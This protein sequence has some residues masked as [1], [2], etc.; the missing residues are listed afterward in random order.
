M[1]PREQACR[2][3]GFVS[4]TPVGVVSFSKETRNIGIC[5]VRATA[6][7]PDGSTTVKLVHETEKAKPDWAGDTPLS[8]VVNALIRAPVLSTVLKMGARR[9]IIKTAE[10]KGI[11]WRQRCSELGRL[12]P[13]SQRAEILASIK[14]PDLQY[15]SYYLNSFHA[16]EAGNLGWLQ[17]FEVG[18]ATKS[19]CVRTFRSEAVLPDHVTAFDRMHESVF[20]AIAANAPVGWA[21]RESFTALDVGCGV[22][23]STRDLARRLL[24]HGVNVARVEG[25]D[26]S[27]YFLAVASVDSEPVGTDSTDV[28]HL[29]S[30]R[31]ALGERTHVEDD[32]LDLFTIQLTTHELPTYATRAIVQEAFRTLKRNSVFALFDNDPKSP[33]IQ[34]LSPVLFTLMKST[35]P[36]LDEYFAI[37]V[38]QLLK[39][40]GFIN[41]ENVRTDPRHRT[42]VATKP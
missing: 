24:K 18:S 38:E 8:K 15:P 31:H 7:Q 6:V 5:S 4:A 35:E 2:E 20:D 10:D 14:D 12:I 1:D 17:A 32:T 11:P 16:Y 29:V 22:G 39:D 23:I 3:L 30:F 41:I 37:D 25:I 27:P 42:I 33:I 21:D 28:E 26:P 13:E 36:F 34:N 19:M 40:V 9:T